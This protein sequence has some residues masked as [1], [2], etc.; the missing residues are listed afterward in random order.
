MQAL[1]MMVRIIEFI[2]RA[3]EGGSSLG[4]KQEK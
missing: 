4:L 1:T 2:L 3:V